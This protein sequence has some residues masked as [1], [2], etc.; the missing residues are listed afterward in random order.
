MLGGFAH[1]VKCQ[2]QFH[3]RETSS[4]FVGDMPSYSWS[5]VRVEGG[6]KTSLYFHLIHERKKTV[7]SLDTGRSWEKYGDILL[8]YLLQFGKRFQRRYARKKYY[9]IYVWKGLE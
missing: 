7:K 1:C 9:F 8:L 4:D 2:Y 3:V 6:T 5:Q